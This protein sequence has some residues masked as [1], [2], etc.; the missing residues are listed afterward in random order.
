MTL[1]DRAMWLVAVA[2]AIWE[3]P[4]WGL[5]IDDEVRFLA[6]WRDALLFDAE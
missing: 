1:E 2:L 6:A 5:M 3:C 4:S